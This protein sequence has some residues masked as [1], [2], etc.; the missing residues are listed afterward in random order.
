MYYSQYFGHCY[1]KLLT[2]TG[3]GISEVVSIHAFC[4]CHQAIPIGS[5]VRT[6]I[7]TV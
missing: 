6:E 3:G 4:A 1:I 2:V 7:T 5:A